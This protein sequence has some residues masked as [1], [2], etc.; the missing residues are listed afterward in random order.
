MNGKNA[1][2]AVEVE[3]LSVT[4]AAAARPA[5]EGVSFAAPA[6]STVG[7]LGPNGSGKSTLFRVLATLLKPTAARPV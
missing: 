4:Y 2:N 3:D 1:L 5:L 7:L 6:G